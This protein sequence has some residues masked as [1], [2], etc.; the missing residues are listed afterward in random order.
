MVVLLPDDR[1]WDTNDTVAPT[2][3]EFEGQQFRF[4]ASSPLL[5]DANNLELHLLGYRGD[6]PAVLAVVPIE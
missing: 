3:F 5:G 1:V 6:E 2:S 4:R